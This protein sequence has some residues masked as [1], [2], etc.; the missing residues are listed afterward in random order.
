[1]E[2]L[3]EGEEEEG[4]KRVK[5]NGRIQRSGKVNGEK[6]AHWGGRGR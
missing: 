4:G 2:L 6:G 1:M 3:R 5:Q